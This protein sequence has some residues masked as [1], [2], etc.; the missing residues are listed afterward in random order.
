MARARSRSSEPGSSAGDD[1]R[2]RGDPLDESGQDASRAD[3]DEGGD[4]GCGH[5]LDGADPVDAGRQVLDELGPAGLGGLDRAAVLVGQQRD[6]RVVEDDPG[7]R[8]AH[9]VGRLGHERGVRR[10]RDRQHDGALG[11][12]RLGELRAGLDGGALTRDDDLPRRVAVGDD[13]D[14]VLRGRLDQLGETRIVEADQR[15]HRA[16]AALSRRLHQ[17]AA[18][19]DEPDAVGEVEGAGRDEGRVLAHRVTGD[20]RR[21][22]RREAVGS[23]SLAQR[24]Q[25]RDRGREDRRLGVLGQ[26]EA[27]GRAVPGQLADRF[28]RAASAAAKTA[29][30]AGEASARVRPIPTDLGALAGTDVCKVTHARSLGA[31]TVTYAQLPCM[32]AYV[33]CDRLRFA[34]CPNSRPA[35][36]ACRPAPP[37]RAPSPARFEADLSAPVLAAGNRLPN[38]RQISERVAMGRALWRELVIGFAGQLGELRLGFTQLAAL[39][40]LADGS[41]LT[42]GE[43]AEAIGR[44]PSAT[45]RLVDGLVRRRLVERHE[46]PEDRRQR[47]LR[48]TQ[49]GHAVLRVVDRA[50]AD[51]SCPR[52]GRCRPP[53]GPS[54]RWAWRPSRPMPSAGA[55]GSSGRR[56]PSR[57]RP[58]GRMDFGPHR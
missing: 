42:V 26:V 17:P 57:R 21:G 34:A 37:R 43:L 5:P 52:S 12:E 22:R 51:S 40:V 56:G 44:S 55:A 53:S 38:V 14:A 11:A 47:T 25:D 39:Y 8:L 1:L 13:E 41:T 6:I 20:E 4:A 48:L 49:R 7:Q 32:V 19:A 46:E 36:A 9:A 15:G 2:L 35:D 45:S 10:D 3:L 16:V 54:W 28:P 29:A 18:L 27:V 24:R 31:R 50:R 23:P 33:P 30:A 58:G